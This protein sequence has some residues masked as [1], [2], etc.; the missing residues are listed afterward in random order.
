MYHAQLRSFHA[1][2]LHGGFSSAARQLNLSQPTVSD[3]VRQLESWFDVR[4]FERRKRS[5]VPTELGTRLYEVTRRLFE[6]E[7]EAVELLSESRALRT[8]SLRVAADAPTHLVDLIGRFRR[9]YPGV[10]V[11][12]SVGNSDE[13]RVKLLEFEADVAALAEAPE[14]DRFERLTLRRDPLVAF[15]NADHPWAARGRISLAELA[16]EPLVMREPGSSTRAILEQELARLGLTPRIA[17]EADRREAAREAVAAGI[18]VGVVSRA[19][20]GFDTRLTAI[21]LSDCRR[22]MTECLVCLRERL[23]LRTVAAFWEIA[24]GGR[25]DA[26]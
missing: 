11:S 13:V 26:A 16:R 1:V 14:D 21:E 5:V 25:R 2:M 24:T 8:G 6:L 17:M 9:A 18:G 19:E 3:Q 4:L 23:Q 20:L 22:D 15:V 12:L 7:A 10:S